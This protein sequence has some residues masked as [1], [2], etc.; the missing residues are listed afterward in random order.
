MYAKVNG[1]E[2]FFDVHGLQFEPK[3]EEVLEKPVTFVLHG[4]P[5]GDHIDFIPW[6]KPLE[7]RTQMVFVDHRSTGRSNRRTLPETWN[8]EQFADDVEEL[9]KYLG[10]ENICVMGESFGGMWSLTY[11][12]RHPHSLRKLILVDTTASW[13]ETWIEAQRIAEKKGDF[14]QRKVFRDVFE[15]RV[16]T[17]EGFRNWDETVAS[18]YYY[19]H[20]KKIS[21]EMRARIRS[22]SL[23]AAYM[24]KNIMPKYDITQ[25]LWMIRC[26]TLVI[27]GRHDWI[28]P[29]SQAQRISQLIP[30]SKLAVFEKSGHMPYV[31]ENSKFLSV[32]AKFL[33][34]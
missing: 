19:K 2:I 18:L 30:N 33:R 1:T 14:K 3:G 20:K 10:L 32:V 17:E 12:I 22:S 25:K 6:L 15:G 27:V 8:I 24:W 9:R 4:G 16:T 26:P 13:K 11:A 28:T 7:K 5:G 29:V 31:E 21:R 34:S 23:V